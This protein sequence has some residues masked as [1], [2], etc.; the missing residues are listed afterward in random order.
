MLEIPSIKF[1]VV[2]PPDHQYASKIFYTFEHAHDLVT[3]N[4]ISP[5]FNVEGARFITQD[6][7]EEMKAATGDPKTVYS[8]LN[9]I[10]DT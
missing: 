3:T 10:W 7:V 2:Y 4:R 8:T 9:K 5:N 6:I 1:G